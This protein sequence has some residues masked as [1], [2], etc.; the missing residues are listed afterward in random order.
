MGAGPYYGGGQ[1]RSCQIL[2]VRRCRRTAATGPPVAGGRVDRARRAD[3]RRQPP[4]G[5]SPA[6][7]AERRL[8]A[9]G[10]GVRAMWTRGG[11]GARPARPDQPRPGPKRCRSGSPTARQAARPLPVAQQRGAHPARRLG[12]D[13]RSV[14]CPH[15]SPAGPR[16]TPRHAQGPASSQRAAHTAEASR[17]RGHPEGQ[18]P[19]RR[20]GASPNGCRAQV[21][22]IGL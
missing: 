2:A 17:T 7:H 13:H 5:S 22:R 19:L 12:G 21:A 11:S 4:I 1:T 15:L 8:R 20:A 14:Q 3:P 6:R 9:C 16:S 10:T 18:R